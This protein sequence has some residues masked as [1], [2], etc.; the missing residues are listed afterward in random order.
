MLL[1]IM[2]FEDLLI[3]MLPDMLFLDII[4]PDIIMDPD[5]ICSPLRIDITSHPQTQCEQ[6]KGSNRQLM[7]FMVIE[8]FLRIIMAWT[9]NS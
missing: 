9:V 1:D 8:C 4:D 3:F 2:L 6:N 5:L 7:S